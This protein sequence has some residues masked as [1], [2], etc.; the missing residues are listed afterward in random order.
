MSPTQRVALLAIS[1]MFA[2][3]LI[4]TQANGYCAARCVVLGFTYVAFATVVVH[5]HVPSR[6]HL[7]L[8][9]AEFL[10][11]FCFIVVGISALAIS[12]V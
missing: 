7:L 11:V 12:Q 1:T 4:V 2:Q 8:T 5:Q 6:P 3:G 10:G 9:E